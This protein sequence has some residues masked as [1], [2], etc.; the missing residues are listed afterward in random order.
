MN[1]TAIYHLNESAFA[2]PLP[3]NRFFLRLRLGKEDKDAK[4]VVHYGKKYVFQDVRLKKEMGLAS[5]SGPFCHFETT[6]ELNDPRLAYVFEITSGDEHCFYSERGV[7]DE[8]DF[9]LAYEDFFQYSYVRQ[10]DAVEVP[11]WVHR[12]VIYQIFPD[13]FHEGKKGK[14]RSYINLKWGDNPT[15]ASFAGGDLMGIVEKLPYL[16]DLGVNAIY[17]TPIFL[18]PSYHKYDTIDYLQIDP[19][20]GEEEDLKTLIASAH[21]KGIRIILD[22]VFNHISDRSPFFLDAKGRG[23][24]SPYRDWFFFDEEGGYQYFSVCPSMPK[25]NPFCPSCGDYLKKVALHYLEMGI[26]GWRLDVSDEVDHAFWKDFRKSI[27]SAYPDSVIIGEHWHNAHA[28]LRGDE[29]DGVM[30][31]PLTYAIVEALARK[32]IDA[33]ALADRMNG[34]LLRYRPSLTPYM[35]NLLDSHD[36]HRFL[37]LAS[38]DRLA[39][40]SALAILVFSPG[41]SCLY[42]GTEVPM[43]GGYDPDSRRC[44][45]WERE[46]A[47]NT[48]KTIVKQ[49]ISLR[50]SDSLSFGRVSISAENG[51]L[52][53]KRGDSGNG[54]ELLVNL[55]KVPVKASG[56]PTISSGYVGNAIQPYGFLIRRY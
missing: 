20:L 27:K 56:R 45:P 31:Y 44:F 8:Y 6:V 46:K 4:V 3:G 53:V 42:Y 39:L 12:A 16:Q 34:L 9:S 23:K 41:M 15:P 17:L 21:E 30:N 49:L 50:K 1:R 19:Q 24:D 26:D 2:E 32:K 29:F 11:E 55:S 13:R 43:E 47:E 28:F 22:A 10:S 37:T 25:L 5:V 52:H 7:L 51:L 33:R 14:D 40:E 54:Y 48:H 36:T 18:S 35:M 38:G